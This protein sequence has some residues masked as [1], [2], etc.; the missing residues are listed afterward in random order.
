MIYAV[1]GTRSCSRVPMGPVGTENKR[2]EKEK[3]E[4]REII[5]L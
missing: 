1:N 5:Y 4:K 3:R 2:K